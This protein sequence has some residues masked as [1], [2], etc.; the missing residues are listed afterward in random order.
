MEYTAIVFDLDGTVADTPDLITGIM[1]G[2][3]AEMDVSADQAA[4]RATIGTPLVDSFAKLMGADDPRVGEA[5][6]I[7]RGRFDLGAEARGTELLFPGVVDGLAKL[8]AAGVRLSIGTSKSLAAATHV[9][10]VCGISDQFETVVGFDNVEH[11]KPAPDT[12]LLAAQRLGVTASDCVVVGDAIGDMRMG[13]AAGMHTLGVSFGVGSAP[14]LYAAG[15][16][17]VVDSFADVVSYV[18]GQ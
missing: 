6:A 1:A 8:R 13:V 11:G 10:D 15:A 18:L 3:L 5:A 14:D 7:Y 17:S 9:L 16:E 4:I 12:A 2:I